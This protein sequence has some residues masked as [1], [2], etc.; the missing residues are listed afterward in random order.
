MINYFIMW[1]NHTVRGK[2]VAIIIE[3]TTIPKIIPYRPPLSIP[4]TAPE[5]IPSSVLDTPRNIVTA[6]VL[7]LSKILSKI[8]LAKFIGSIRKVIS[9]PILKS[10]WEF[11]FTLFAKDKVNPTFSPLVA[12]KTFI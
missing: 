6:D 12:S 9:S 8:S 4:S 11:K 5:I 1:K 7:T 10:S 2:Q 3:I